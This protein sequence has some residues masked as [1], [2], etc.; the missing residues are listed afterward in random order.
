MPKPNGRAWPALKA[1]LDAVLITVGFVGAY[2]WR[3]GLQW[4]RQVEPEYHQPYSVYLPMS[5]VS[6]AVLLL[7]YWLDGSY[8]ARRGRS[9][10]DE[11]YSIFRSTL[12]GIATVIFFI[13]LFYGSYYSRLIFFY[14][15]IWVLLLLGLS[16]GVERVVQ[17]EL[18]RR[19]IGVTRTLIVGAGEAGRTIMRNLAA[20]LSFKIRHRNL[21]ER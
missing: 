18:R 21:L 14:A 16:R 6:T 15:G 3:Y 5:L 12:S 7:F 2:W 1:A 8:V 20:D 11:M 17:K 19:G 4:F 10:F 13:F 9:W